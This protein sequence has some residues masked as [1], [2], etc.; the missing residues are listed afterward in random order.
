MEPAPAMSP[1]PKSPAGPAHDTVQLRRD[2]F[3]AEIA[4]NR[5]PLNL[6]TGQML[7]DL[8]RV[9]RDL[10]LEPSLRCVIL[11]QGDARA[12]CAG[13][14]MRE[15]EALRE[16][17]L[18]SKIL[19]EEFVTRQ[20]AQLPC[21]TIAA[22]DGPAL[23]GGFELALACDLRVAAVHA[24]VGLTE[25]QIGGLGG[26]GAV[27][28]TRLAGPARAAEMLFTGRVIQ[29]DQACAWG[30]VNEVAQDRSALQRARELA[31]EIAARGP[32]SNAF[33]KQLIA[34]AQDETCAGALA[35]ANE[36]QDRIFQSED[37]Q[38]GAR[39]FFARSPVHFEGR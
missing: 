13:S 22:L 19:F 12:F 8:H 32:L 4:L 33:A 1:S 15:F 2:G 20:L 36:L 25:C 18:E 31:A 16:Q 14:D 7:Q 38:R 29:A 6:V 5:P 17:A 24:S 37:L 35:L 10:S 21:P 11:H 30:L 3:V 28:L 27:R 9:V 39:A 26:S 34:A 23:G